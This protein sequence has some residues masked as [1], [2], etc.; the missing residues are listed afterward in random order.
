ME[1]SRREVARLVVEM[2]E[3]LPFQ[4][5]QT[6]INAKER[7]APMNLISYFAGSLSAQL[8]RA[9]ANEANQGHWPDP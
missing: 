2:L 9:R 3:S 1:G 5:T 4:L 7:N 6:F 8:V